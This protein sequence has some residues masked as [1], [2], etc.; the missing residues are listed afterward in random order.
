VC[1]RASLDDLNARM[2]EPIPMERF[3][4]NIVLNGLPPFAEDRI[5]LVQVGSVTLK[6]VKPCTRCVI[7]STDQSTGERSTNPL[8]YLRE[9]RFDRN[10]LGVTFGENAVV[11]AGLGT[12]IE[13]DAEC[14]I[15]F[16]A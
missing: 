5:D 3:R 15:T 9:F 13:R 11:V 6:L 10:L 16:D 4:P 8:P 2:P 1:N 7:T 12:N 14:V